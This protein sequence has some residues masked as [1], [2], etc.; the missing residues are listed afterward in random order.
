M[1]ALDGIKK[2]YGK[3]TVLDGITL[4]VRDGEIV[5]ILGP[6]GSGK[7][8][9]LNIILGITAPPPGA[10]STTA[11]TLRGPRWSAGDSISCFRTTRFS[12]T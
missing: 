5:S 8:T 10:S 2:S 6:S 9:L 12:R 3:E 11:K 1:L 7:T 4:D